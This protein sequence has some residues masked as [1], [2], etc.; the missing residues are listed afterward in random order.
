MHHFCIAAFM[1]WWLAKLGNMHDNNDPMIDDMVKA[2]L[3]NWIRTCDPPTQSQ[4]S[5]RP[6]N[7]LPPQQY[8]RPPFYEDDRRSRT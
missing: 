6:A 4:K 5:Y 1:A 8:N 7:T 3:D 2:P